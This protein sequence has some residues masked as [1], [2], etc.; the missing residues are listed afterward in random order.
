[1][2]RPGSYSDLQQLQH[3]PQTPTEAA[4][5]AAEAAAALGIPPPPRGGTFSAPSSPSVAVAAG[6]GR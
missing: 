5:A 2:R 6:D 1:M 4:I 3:Q